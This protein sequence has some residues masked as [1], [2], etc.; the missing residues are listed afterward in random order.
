MAGHD[1]TALTLAWTWYLVGQHPAVHDALQAELA[2]VLGGRSPTPADLPRLP[3]TER[4]VLETM[5]LYP[6]AYMLGRQAV[7]ACELGG[8]WLPAGA[9]VLMSQ[10]LL[11]RDPRW[12]DD[13][14][15]FDP[16]RWADD[17]A[18][19]LPRFVYFPFGGGSRQCIGN[20]F[21]M[22]EACLI[23]ATLAQRARVT[24]VPGPPVRPAPA[25]TLKPGRGVH[26]VVRLTA[27]RGAA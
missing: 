3:Y 27:K 19:R 4:V 20:S 9:T 13:P 7:A 11:H 24:L 23:L 22:M 18:K 10:W 21:A 17:L 8:Y 25:I 26:A 1:T 5:R 14:E 12:F 6:A 16:D 2:S 15:R